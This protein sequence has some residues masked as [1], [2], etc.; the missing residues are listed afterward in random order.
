[1]LEAILFPLD[2]LGDAAFV[3]YMVVVF[4]WLAALG[5]RLRRLAA[6]AA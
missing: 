5:A 1:V 4:G 2:F 6:V 3:G